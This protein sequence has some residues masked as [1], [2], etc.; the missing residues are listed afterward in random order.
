MWFCW[1]LL[2]SDD[3]KIIRGTIGGFKFVSLLLRT[4]LVLHPQLLLY[5]L[6]VSLTGPNNIPSWVSCPFWSW[7]GIWSNVFASWSKE[8]SHGGCLLLPVASSWTRS[9]LQMVQFSMEK[10]DW[11]LSEAW[12]LLYWSTCSL[13]FLVSVM[14]MVELGLQNLLASQ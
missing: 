4:W 2:C 5:L 7:Y 6:P 10:P 11:T 13:D 9:G 8:A 1:F 3:D 12:S 14:D